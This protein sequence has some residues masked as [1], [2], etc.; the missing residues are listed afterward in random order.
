MAID[1]LPHDPINLCVCGTLAKK[2]IT[3]ALNHGYHKKQTLLLPKE[4]VALFIWGNKLTG[5]IS[6]PLRFHASKEVARKYLATCK[7]D[8]WSNKHFNAVDWE[9]LDLALKSK[10]DMY[11]IWRSKQHLS[12]C[13]MR[14]Q[15]GRYSGEI[16]PDKRCPNCGWREFAAHLMLCPNENRTQ[17]LIDTVNE[18]T[19]WMAKDSITNPKILYWIPKYILMRGDKPC[20]QMG[21]LCLLSSRHLLTART[22]LDGGISPKVISQHTSMQFRHSI[23]GC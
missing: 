19:K 6:S 8:K 9:H 18:L 1:L 23:S 22:S 3:T 17:L 20:S 15:V 16:L 14:V 2:S 11:K 13:G 12:F 4:D 7:K 21:V 10:E 5:N